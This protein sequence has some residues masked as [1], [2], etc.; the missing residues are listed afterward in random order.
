MM[1]LLIHLI[2]AGAIA[3]GASMYL[4]SQDK[5]AQKAIKARDAAKK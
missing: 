1:K 2:I 5:S 3:Y 4:Q